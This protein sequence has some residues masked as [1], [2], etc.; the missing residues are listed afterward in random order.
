[1][2]MKYTVI[3]GIILLFMLVPP[4]VLAHGGNATGSTDSP[5]GM[6][7][8]MEDR[9]VDGETY[10]EME[11]LMR[12]MMA[13]EL[14]KEESTRLTELMQEHPGVHATMMNRM[15]GGSA[16][17]MMSGAAM[18]MME[19]GS[20]QQMPSALMGLLWMSGLLYLVW[21]IVG[22]LAIIWLWR[23]ITRPVS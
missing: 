1:M 3:T 18:P 23:Q 13:G 7:R 11:Q 22:V 8:M 6:M 14:T 2:D 5:A 16:G 12:N 10:R 19:T 15:T 9:A 20:V 4:L 21:L 17:G